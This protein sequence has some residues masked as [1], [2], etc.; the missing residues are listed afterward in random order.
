MIIRNLFILILTL[1][2]IEVLSNPIK[3]YN[4]PSNLD[5]CKGISITS[6]YFSDDIENPTILQVFKFGYDESGSYSFVHSKNL[7]YTSDEKYRDI[8]S[9]HDLKDSPRI[10]SSIYRG[11]IVSI[12]LSDILREDG[13]T[14]IS[15]KLKVKELLDNGIKSVLIYPIIDFKS[16][17]LVGFIFAGY[18]YEVVYTNSLYFRFEFLSKALIPVLYECR[19]NK[20]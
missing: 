8:W 1:L 5:Y 18:E 12:Y 11:S 7:V 13:S 3:E 17:K 2:P 15:T 4:V 6:N 20:Q 19:K 10:I 9:N 14:N 16:S